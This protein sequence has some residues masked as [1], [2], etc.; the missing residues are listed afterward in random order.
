[1]PK[2]YCCCG[3]DT[4]PNGNCL[5]FTSACF[6]QTYR[7]TADFLLRFLCIPDDGSGSFERISTYTACGGQVFQMK[8]NL[9]H[10]RLTWEHTITSSDNNPYDFSF[11][12]AKPGEYTLQLI[13][14]GTSYLTI[15]VGQLCDTNQVGCVSVPA[16]SYNCRDIDG[17]GQ[18][19]NYEIYINLNIGYKETL[20]CG[21]VWEIPYVYDDVFGGLFSCGNQT[22]F[23]WTRALATTGESCIATSSLNGTR[24]TSGGCNGYYWSQYLTNCNYLETTDHYVPTPEWTSGGYLCGSN[25]MQLDGSYGNFIQKYFYAYRT[26]LVEKI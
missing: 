9:E 13:S 7:F 17:L 16:I 8:Q 25:C 15:D 22:Y 26:L 5:Q 18:R 6:G 11:L 2:K 12:Y 3:S 24:I 21:E 10:W 1:M 20:P 23:R 4:P 19:D 14:P